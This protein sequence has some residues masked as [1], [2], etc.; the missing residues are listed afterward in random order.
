[1]FRETPT[2]EYFGTKLAEQAYKKGWR[3]IAM[4]TEIKDFPVSYS[5]AFSKA[6]TALGG[7]IVLD[8]RFAPG[9]NDYRT[10]VIKLKGLSYD[11]VFVSTQGADTAGTITT[12]IKDLGLEKAYLYTHTFTPVTFFKTTHGYMPANYLVVNPYVDTQ[13]PKVV[14]FNAAYVAKYG[15][16]YNF[17]PY[18][19]TA[20]YD[21]V[22][23]VRDAGNTCAANGGFS[24]DCVRNQ[25]KT[26]KS[27]SGVAGESVISSQYS[28]DGVLAPVGL[29]KVM[30]TGYT[31]VPLQ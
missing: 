10:E 14:A 12:Q 22:N 30:G 21:I 19:I 4:L 16:M 28:P 18:F 2:N 29:V 26:A 9:L 6:F 13:S 25:F 1:M 11:A 3:S 27:Y 17:T 15:Q 8:E 5:D 7:K 20:D 24:I 31:I 23:R